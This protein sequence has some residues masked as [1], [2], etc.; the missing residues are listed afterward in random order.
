MFLHLVVQDGVPMFG[1]IRLRK[2]FFGQP[3]VDDVLLGDQP[4]DSDVDM[5][6]GDDDDPFELVGLPG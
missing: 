3:H 6:V 4:A 5:L 1:G 2:R